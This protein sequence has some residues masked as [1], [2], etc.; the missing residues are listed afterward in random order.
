MSFAT[1]YGTAYK[2]LREGRV[3][4]TLLDKV[5]YGEYG[6]DWDA[7]RA[8]RRTFETVRRDVFSRVQAAIYA[9]KMVKEMRRQKVLVNVLM[10]I[11]DESTDKTAVPAKH[12]HLFPVTVNRTVVKMQK[13]PNA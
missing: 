13:D 9:F 8:D 12:I 11:A 10:S 4:R 5:L 7:R 1:D 3:D 6:T 2:L